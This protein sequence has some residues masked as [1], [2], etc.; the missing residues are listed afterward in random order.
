MVKV[1]HWPVLWFFTIV[2]PSACAGAGSDTGICVAAIE[3]MGKESGTW[4]VTRRTI[5]IKS[6]WSKRD[7]SLLSVL[8]DVVITLS[9]SNSSV[10]F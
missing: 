8:L 9:F 4:L 10:T 6:E 3:G 2:E 5:Q 7:Q 1:L